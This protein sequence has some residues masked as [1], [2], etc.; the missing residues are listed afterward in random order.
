[1][2]SEHRWV[3]SSGVGEVVTCTTV[4]RPPT[5]AFDP[6]YV[7]AVVRLEEGHE[8]LTNIIGAEPN[9]DLVGAPVRVR[10][11]RESEEITLPLFELVA[12]DGAGE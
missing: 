7:V 2:S 3:A 5:P 4:W 10:F 11:Q 1:M 12:I 8:M 6:P 9:A